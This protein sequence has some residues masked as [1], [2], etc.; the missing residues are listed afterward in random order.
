MSIGA[1]ES[2][3]QVVRGGLDVCF[4]GVPDKS[5]CRVDH[6]NMASAR[7]YW[8]NNSCHYHLLESLH[9][10]QKQWKMVGTLTERW[11]YA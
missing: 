5:R 3:H 11:A 2:S 1:K 7:N 10:P 8:W 6:R 9:I 4:S